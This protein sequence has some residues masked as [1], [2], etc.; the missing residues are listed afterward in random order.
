MYWVP[1]SEYRGP[2]TWTQS[3]QTI[4]SSLYKAEN[5]RY[6]VIQCYLSIR[7]TI[8]SIV[9][10]CAP[11]CRYMDIW[12]T[13]LSLLRSLILNKGSQ[14]TQVKW[15]D[16]AFSSTELQERGNVN[17]SCL[18]QCHTTPDLGPHAFVALCP[19]V[20][21]C[22]SPVCPCMSLVY[23]SVSP[24]YPSTKVSLCPYPVRVPTCPYRPVYPLVLFCTKLCRL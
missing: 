22:V 4:V 5:T 19:S 18:C 2:S 6:E 23:P 7:Y 11:G 3:L 17:L 10:V 9:A 24:V 8:A 21:P 1:E 16:D 14:A 13:N 15:K 12:A 20:S